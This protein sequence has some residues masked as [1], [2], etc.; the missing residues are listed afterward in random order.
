MLTTGFT[1]GRQHGLARVAH[2]G[3]VAPAQA[4]RHPELTFTADHV[5]DAQATHGG[6]VGVQQLAPGLAAARGQ[7][8]WAPGRQAPGLAISRESVRRCTDLGIQ[9]QQLLVTP[10]IGPVGAHA[11]GQVGNQSDRHAGGTSALLRLLEL[12]VGQPLEVHGKLDF[13]RATLNKILT[14]GGKPVAPG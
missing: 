1:Q 14:R 11:H 7:L 5:V 3:A 6:H 8:L 12:L 13:K 10:G 2:I 4:P 9:R